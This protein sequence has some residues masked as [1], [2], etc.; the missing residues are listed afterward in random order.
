MKETIQHCLH[1]PGINGL[2]GI[3]LLIEG[4]PGGAK[5]S[6]INQIAEA[7]GLHL[8]TV[9]LS[10]REPQDVV[11]VPV[12][13]G[14]G[15]KI[16]PP[17]W[18]KRLI[19]AGEGILF[20][21]ELACATPAVQ[22]AALRIV[23]ERVV[24]DVA[25]PPTIR[26]IAATNSTEESAGGWEIAPPLANRFMHIKWHGPRSSEWSDW[27]LG[28]E[29]EH[30]KLNIPDNESWINSLAQV[31]GVVS[32]FLSVKPNLLGPSVPDDPQKASRAWP[33]PR[34]WNMAV[35]AL[36]WCKVQ[37]IEYMPFIVGLLG[38]GVA[39][40]FATYEF[41]KDLPE[42]RALLNGEKTFQPDKRVDKTLA[43]LNAISAYTIA[44]PDNAPT[45]WKLLSS[46]SKAAEARDTMV[47]AARAL[48]KANLIHCKEATTA[49]SSLGDLAKNLK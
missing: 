47:P 42:P 33:S 13:T 3:P 7:E 10:V 28:I 38:D 14:D 30:K 16:E 44:F 20:L 25:L 26:I 49:L 4:P 18:C 43:V 36:A 41:Y 32:A 27:L 39:K 34:S 21:D 48:I 17:A 40:E 9:I 15:V 5:T 22:A 35:N 19:K 31:K 29:T 11:G 23:A 46:I 8:E 45:A 6:M 37:N 24:G 12:L 2:S 1:I